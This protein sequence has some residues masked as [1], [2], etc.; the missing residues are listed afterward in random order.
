MLRARLQTTG[1][2]LLLRCGGLRVVPRKLTQRVRHYGNLP[3]IFES[4]SR[5]LCKRGL[6][7]CVFWLCRCDRGLLPWALQLP[8]GSDG[9]C[10]R[11]MAR[12][13][14]RQRLCCHST[15]VLPGRLTLES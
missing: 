9:F 1:R 12:R 5:E 14:P 2:L 10:C 13:R 6:F 4:T 7:S 3:F 8:L 15:R 11:G